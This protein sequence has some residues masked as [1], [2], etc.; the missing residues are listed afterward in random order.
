MLQTTTPLADRLDP[1]KL[2]FVDVDG[3]RTRYYED[4]A[5]EPLVIFHGG[6]FGSLYSLDCWS[7]NFDGLA[8]RFH[9]YAVD[10]LGQGYTDP[11]LCDEDYT[12][13]GLIR[14][15]QGVLDALGIDAA[16]LMGHS[17]GALLA[18]R[19]VLAK[20][21]RARTLVIVDSDSTAPRLPDVVPG[22]FYA[23]I[24]ERTPPGPPT[25]AT[26]RLEPDA[27]AYSPEQVTDD[28]LARMLEI[29]QLLPLQEAQERMKTLAET[30]WLPSLEAQREATLR[31]IDEVG[32][33]VPTLVVWGFNDRSAPLRVGQALFQRICAR[34]AHAEMHIL[35]H[36]G[37]YSFREQPA[38]FN[39]LLAGFCLA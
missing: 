21:E 35:N 15:E 14:H 4:G 39:R 26:V 25:L 7:L 5:G 20:P 31:T 8:E 29:A 33:P 13:G 23:E 11:P 2:R 16:H 27:Q 34:T 22:T 17:R 1:A 32:L 36:A 18:T 38:A 24:A 10:K 6:Q 3:I 30:H 12:L 37:H 19:L 9:V 28:F